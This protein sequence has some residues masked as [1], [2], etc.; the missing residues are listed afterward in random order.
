MKSVT[1]CHDMLIFMCQWHRGNEGHP[2]F[3]MEKKKNFRNVMFVN[4]IR[5]RY[6]SVFRTKRSGCGRIG[7]NGGT[8]GSP[9]PSGELCFQENER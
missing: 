6:I 2:G 9:I 3:S 5:R 1:F 7:I 8:S 4:R